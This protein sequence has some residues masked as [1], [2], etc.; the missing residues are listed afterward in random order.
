MEQK[1]QI[2]RI[3][4]DIEFL[5]SIRPYRNYL[6]VGS[7]NKAA[8]YI[9]QTF[10]EF[11][12]GAYF[13]EF[14]I[15]GNRYKNVI[16][17]VNTHLEERIIIGA[18]YDVAG[19]TP[20]AD[21]NASGVAGL[22][23]LLRLLHNKK[24][25]YRIDFAAYTLEEPPFFGTKKMGSF[26]HAQSL[27]KEKAKIKVMIS[28]EMIGYFSDEEGSQQFPLPF[29]KLLYP[30]TGNFIGVIGN[31]F[32]RGITKK[33]RDLMRKGSDI[34]VYSINAP[35][36]IPGVDFSDHRNFWYFGYNAVMI[37]D[38]AFYRNPNYHRKTDNI[39]TLDLKKM[40][41]VIQGLKY[42][43]LNL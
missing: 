6:N 43:V 10:K 32:Q 11:S 9:Y 13:Q 29:M 28:L 27:Y 23:E 20:G 40:H 30:E 8:D 38:T 15:G 25:N 36:I 17:S 5:T 1:K 16:C 19:D 33:I 21:D 35:T 14:S 22:L 12:E 34:P 31:L 42:A 3:Y 2:E 7:L 41:S 39:G 26:I 24:T 18:H 37:T 4:K